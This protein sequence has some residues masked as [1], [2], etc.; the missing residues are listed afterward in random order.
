M[1]NHKLAILSKSF[2]KFR[3]K[4]LPLFYRLRTRP[5]RRYDTTQLYHTIVLHHGTIHHGTT[6]IVLQHD[7]APVSQNKCCEMKPNRLVWIFLRSLNDCSKQFACY[8]Q[9]CWNAAKADT[10]SQLKRT[11][12]AATASNATK[13]LKPNLGLVFTTGHSAT[14]LSGVTCVFPFY[15]NFPIFS[16]ISRSLFLVSTS[17]VVI[18]RVLSSALI[19]FRFRSLRNRSSRV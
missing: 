9:R 12:C 15:D 11:L 7:T 16:I 14:M 6:H 3:T 13:M 17:V 1:P 5:I 18:N 2:W 4:I 8:A 19:K 10:C